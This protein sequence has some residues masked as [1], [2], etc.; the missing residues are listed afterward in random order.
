MLMLVVL[1]I[2]NL[3]HFLAL[4]IYCI[5]D[6]FSHAVTKNDGFST[7]LFYS[8]VISVTLYFFLTWNLQLFVN[9]RMQTDFFVALMFLLWKY[10]GHV[11]FSFKF[12]IIRNF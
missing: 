2:K 11:M 10:F 12:S 5:F 3:L 6:D 4:K 7:Q 9:Y 1:G 8:Y